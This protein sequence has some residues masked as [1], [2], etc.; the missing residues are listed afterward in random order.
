MAD[1]DDIRYMSRAL[2]LAR[3]GLYTTDPNPRVGCV[4]V[5]DGEIV[6]EGWHERAGQPHAEVHALRAAGARARG[7]TAYVT[8]EPCSHHG[9]TPPCSEAL[10][11]AGVDRVVAAMQD[12]NPQVA[13]EGLARLEAA[14][15]VTESGVLASESAALNPGFIQRMRN[16][17]PWVR[18]K[19]AMS[20]D[21]RTALA[22]GESQWITG[23]AARADVH[24]LR[25]RSSAILTGSGTVLADDPSLTARPDGMDDSELLQPLRV[26][27]DTRLTLAPTA[28][29]LSQP[30]QTLVLTASD[31]AA[32]RQAL[33]AAGAEVAVL[34]VRD[35]RLDLP[36]ALRLLG[37][38]ELNEV[39]VEAGPTLAGAMLQAGLVD[40]LIIYMA[41]QLLGDAAR[42]LFHLPGLATMA[43]RVALT[44]EDI[45]AVG[46]DW[47]IRARLK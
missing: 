38:R 30:G 20:L 37:E 27:L 7:A 17:R 1:A 42:G 2:Q 40:E 14:G 15:I 22:S 13:G 25:A 41:P 6:G 19:L 46:P 35:D 34:P 29:L 3:R 8:L 24:R 4:L 18:C 10:I 16:G 12:P 39:M 26:V 9:R 28:K 11:G 43:D 21:G 33:E 23:P 31:D 44:I 45:R 5:K 47:R 36:A 32:R